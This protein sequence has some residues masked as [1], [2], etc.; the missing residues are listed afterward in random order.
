M[1]I[2]IDKF[3]YVEKVQISKVDMCHAYKLKNAR[4]NGFK[5]T[6]YE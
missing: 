3:A 2:F 5:A 4:Y 1:V 6:L